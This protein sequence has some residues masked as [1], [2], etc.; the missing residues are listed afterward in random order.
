MP[1][2]NPTETLWQ[3]HRAKVM[4]DPTVTQLNAGTCSPTPKPVFDRVSELRRKQAQSPTEFQWR[5]AWQ[6]LRRSRRALGAYLNGNE[7]DFALL[8]NVTVA[9]N[10][11][12]QSLQ[13]PAG[14][15]VLTSDHEYGSIVA[16][17]RRLANDR[18]WTFRTVELPG[19]IEDPQQIVDAFSQ[20]ISRHTKVLTFSHISSPSGLIFP[21]EALCALARERGLITVIDGA[22]APGQVD[23]DLKKIDA[24]FYTANCHKWMMAPASV[25]FLHAGPRLKHLAHSVVSSWGHGYAPE[26][27]EDEAFPG[28][29]KWQYDLEFHGTT[30][31]SPQMVLEEVVKFRNEIGGND[32]VFARVRHLATEL[33]LRLRGIGLTPFLPHDDRLVATMTTF[34]LPEKYQTAGGFIATPTD[35]P[36][37][38]LQR[39]LWDKHRIECPTTF[40]AGKVFL[41]VSTAWFNTVE[42]IDRLSRALAETL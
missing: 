15:E 11:A 14:A 1:D 42:E 2:V 29:S 25:G 30:D 39:R 18:G 16:L 24:D 12:A 13:L 35:S 26:Q 20:A 36:A 6:H 32:A 10:I 34:I 41:R 19:T 7:R 28:T 3:S 22:H 8:E 23:V 4:L 17:F 37:Q 38:Q 9:L 27:A 31:R 21:A 5:D 33:R 40:S